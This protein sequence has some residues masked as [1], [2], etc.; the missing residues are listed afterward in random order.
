MNFRL[1]LVLAEHRKIL[2]HRL[3]KILQGSND[4]Y[5]KPKLF[6]LNR[7]QL[8]PEKMLLTDYRFDGIE[9]WW[10]WLKSEDISFDSNTTVLN[11]IV[12]T[13]ESNTMLY[14]LNQALATSMPIIIVGD[15]GAGKSVTIRHFLNELPK[16]KFLNCILNLAAN[17]SA[18][19]VQELVMTKLDRRRKGVFGPP[20][21]KQS[22][23]FADNL[24]IPM[25]DQY[26]SQAPVEL[27]RQW[28]DHS[29]WSD[30]NDSSKIELVDLVSHTIFRSESHL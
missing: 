2:D 11:A 25:R 19:Q 12:P 7:G 26:E 9:T 1:F 21:G 14:W 24:S 27:L 20:V 4:D 23:I 28:I 17:T 5:P 15:T 13:K 8:F 30:L 29:Y 22:I 6:T 10:P 16:E 3:R 18:Q